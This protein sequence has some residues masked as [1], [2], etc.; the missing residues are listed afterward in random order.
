MS[1]QHPLKTLTDLV[2]SV[3]KQVDAC[4]VTSNQDAKDYD[5][6]MDANEL[7]ALEIEKLHAIIAEQKTKID[8]YE[9]VILIASNRAE[10]DIVEI[11]VL[12]A[13][14]DELT[15]QDSPR[16][17]KQNKGYKKTIEEGKVNLAK[18]KKQYADCLTDLKYYRSASTVKGVTPFYNNPETG[19]TISLVPNTRLH[20]GNPMKGVDKSPVVE[21]FHND[22]GISRRGFIGQDGNMHWASATNSTP[23]NDEALVAKTFIKNYCKTNNIKL[24]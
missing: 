23:T 11:Q 19:N 18:V 24:K 16:L 22:R 1:E 8:K 10:A 21:F 12:K 15:V 9:G 3:A 20:V 14:I 6:V 5:E 2:D 7:Q 17:L 13:K 4:I